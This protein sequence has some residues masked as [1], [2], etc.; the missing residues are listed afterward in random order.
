MKKIVLYVSFLLAFLSGAAQSQNWYQ[1]GFKI[2]AS[3]PTNRMYSVDNDYLIS[4]TAADFG[5][6]FRAGKYVYGEVG[7][8][9]AF[10]KGDYTV[11]LADGSNLFEPARVELR[12]LQIPVKAV[13]NV[14]LTRTLSLL[15]FAGIIWQPLVKVTGN[16]IGYNK[17]T[18]KQSVL[19][20]SGLDF[21]LG[22]IVLGVNYRYS[23]TRFFQNKEGKHPQY[24]NVCVGFQL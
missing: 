12:H 9:Y 24:V 15:P 23:L 22:P 21:K 11:K 5:A 3:F 10:Y 2:S 1:V 7:F 17:N 18:L 16:D 13:G 6:F 8:G 20:T 14:P 19:F 4:L